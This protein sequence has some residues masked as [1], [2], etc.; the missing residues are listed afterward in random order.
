MTDHTLCEITAPGPVGLSWAPALSIHWPSDVTEGTLLLLLLRLIDLTSRPATATAAATIASWQRSLM[1][2]LRGLDRCWTKIELA[3]S[4]CTLDS[5]CAVCRLYRVI[6]EHRAAVHRLDRARLS[7]G[8]GCFSPFPGP[9]CSQLGG[10]SQ[11]SDSRETLCRLAS[12]WWHAMDHVHGYKDVDG[13][14]ES[15]RLAR[16][17]LHN[18]LNKS[19]TVRLTLPMWY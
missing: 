17:C 16:R 14:S 10:R 12:R 4:V 2:Q 15:V 19:G 5:A 6:G 8:T 1:T 7:H 3:L 9:V 18:Q 11:R 13:C